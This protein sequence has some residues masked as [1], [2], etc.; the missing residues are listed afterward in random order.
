MAQVRVEM[1]TRR[2]ADPTSL[3]FVRDTS[4]DDDAHIS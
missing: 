3:G 2:C 1:R 4:R